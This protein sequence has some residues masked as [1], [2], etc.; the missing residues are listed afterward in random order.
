MHPR[1]TMLLLMD[2]TKYHMQGRSA[3]I[4]VAI[5]TRSRKGTRPDLLVGK[6]TTKSDVVAETEAIRLRG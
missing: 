1:R 4:Y 5:A 6:T 3:I 2:Q